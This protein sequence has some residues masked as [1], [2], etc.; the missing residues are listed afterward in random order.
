MVSV[1]TAGA[2]GTLRV[3]VWR[4]LR[5]LGALYVQQ[6]VCLLPARAAVVR[7]VRRLVDRVCHQG[8]TARVLRVELIDPDEQAGV[9]AE[10]NAARD[11]EYA[12]LMERLPAFSAELEMERA[13]GR[14][15]YVEVEENEADLERF[16]SWLSKIAARDY[17]EAPLGAPARAAVEAAATELAAFEAEALRREAPAEAGG[18]GG[19]SADGDDPAGRGGPQLRVV[20]EQ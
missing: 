17:F 19:Q 9:I 6:S 12:D 11:T 20:N 13:R 14:A 4:K 5:S 3:Q 18:P 2:P 15:S 8:G 16:R 1:S 7:E 10:L